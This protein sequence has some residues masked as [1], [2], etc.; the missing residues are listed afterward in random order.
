MLAIAICYAPLFVT[1]TSQMIGKLI[2]PTPEP[3]GKNGSFHGIGMHIPLLCN[4][5]ASNCSLNKVYCKGVHICGSIAYVPYS[6]TL[7][8]IENPEFFP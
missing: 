8:S 5:V 4:F 7:L 1:V 3:Y 6:L 2:I